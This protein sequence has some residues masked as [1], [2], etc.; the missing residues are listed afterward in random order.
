MRGG[1]KIQKCFPVYFLPSTPNPAKD[2]AH[3]FHGV[4]GLFPSAKFLCA[5]CLSCWEWPHILFIATVLANTGP[6]GSAK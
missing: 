3:R 4:V 1:G 2:T 5:Q 6:R